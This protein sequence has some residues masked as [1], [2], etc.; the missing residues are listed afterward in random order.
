[1]QLQLPFTEAEQEFNLKVCAGFA[2]L[3]LNRLRNLDRP[4]DRD[5]ER[6]KNWELG[7]HGNKHPLYDFIKGILNAI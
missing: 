4:S 1:M 5:V 6:L 2:I 3:R 7:F